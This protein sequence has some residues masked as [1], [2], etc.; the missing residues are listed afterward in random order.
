MY[1]VLLDTLERVSWAVVYRA[2]IIT[3]I[4]K[5]LESTRSSITW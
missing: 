4:I 2:Y 3:I 1:G 5:V